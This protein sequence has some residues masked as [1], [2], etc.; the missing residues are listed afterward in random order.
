M[1]HLVKKSELSHAEQNGIWAFAW[2]P[3]TSGNV[4]HDHFEIDPA[5]GLE[6]PI[7]RLNPHN[8]HMAAF[9]DAFAKHPDATIALLKRFRR[10]ICEEC[11]RPG[12]ST[13]HATLISHGTTNKAAEILAT[14]NEG[15]NPTETNVESSARRL[16]RHRQELKKILKPYEQNPDWPV[17]WNRA[18]GDP[19]IRK[20]DKKQDK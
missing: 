1:H 17:G 15:S 6:D 12:K 18:S 14:A 9:M 2:L 10:F 19:I 20:Q 13:V 3:E 16:R 11:G 5:N 8:L 4:K 7:D